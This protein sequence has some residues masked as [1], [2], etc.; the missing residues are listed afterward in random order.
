MRYIT[1]FVLEDLKKKMVFIGGP[2]QV[3]KT[4]LAKDILSTI[5]P[6]GRYLNWDFDEDRQDI[7]HKRWSADNTLLVFDELH[8]FPK[9]K[10]WIKGIYDVSL[11]THSFLVTGSPIHEV[12]APGGVKASQSIFL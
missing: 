11:E 6:A 10:R 2:R 3:G 5:F 1:P 7:L 9:W 4:M 12:F 8:K